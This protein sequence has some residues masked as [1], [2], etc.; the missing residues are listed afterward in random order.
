M[1][2]FALLVL[3]VVSMYSAQTSLLT[4]LDYHGVSANLMLLLVVSTGFLRGTYFGVTMGFC[5]GLLQDF[6]SGDF[7]GC[8]TFAYMLVGLIFGKFSENVVKEQFLLP[9]LSAPVAATIYFFTMTLFIYLLGYPIYIFQSMQTVL[10]PLIFY[11]LI[12][13]LPVHKLAYD[14]DKFVRELGARG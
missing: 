12:F 10:R 8:S 5:V 2:I 1:K 13:S 7:F 14:F 6:T 11:Q 3:I 9:V 4:Y